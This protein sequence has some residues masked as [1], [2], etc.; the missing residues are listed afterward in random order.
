[1]RGK[2]H[3]PHGLRRNPKGKPASAGFFLPSRL[4]KV[5]YADVGLSARR[6]AP[7]EVVSFTNFDRR[8]IYERLLVAIQ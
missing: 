3:L 6:P 2:G 1:M 7:S 8:C 4:G 5:V